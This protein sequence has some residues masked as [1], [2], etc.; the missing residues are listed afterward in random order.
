MTS[1][2]RL[3]FSLLIILYETASVHV[4]SV[5]LLLLTLTAFSVLC[6]MQHVKYHTVLLS[7]FTPNIL[8][9]ARTTIISVF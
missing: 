2:C 9:E 4:C 8:Q 3:M 1:V 7:T 5:L 6:V